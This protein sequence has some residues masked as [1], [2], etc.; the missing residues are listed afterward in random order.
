MYVALDIWDVIMTFYML[1]HEKF[2]LAVFMVREYLSPSNGEWNF[3]SN[4]VRSR[5]FTNPIDQI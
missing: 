5:M 1:E 2:I 4:E 3:R